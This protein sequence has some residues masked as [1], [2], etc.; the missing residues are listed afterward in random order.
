MKQGNKIRTIAL[1]SAASIMIGMGSAY[2]ATTTVTSTIKFI[3]DLS[4]TEVTPPNFGYAKAGAAGTYILK[5][6]GTIDAA[7]TG[8]PEGG[9]LAA[10][11]YTITGS[12]SQ[13]INISVGNYVADGASTPSAAT[14]NYNSAGEVPCTDASMT[15]AAAPGAGT[16]LK[17]GLTV[18]AAG[19][20]TDGEVDHPKMDLTVLYQ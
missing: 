2:A 14:C 8:T 5:T 20:S 18:T 11:D 13:A 3:T 4:V 12:A 10:G 7:S 16:D 9:T 17:L 19:G 1:L 15:G 6:D